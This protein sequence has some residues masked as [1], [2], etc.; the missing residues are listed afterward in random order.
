MGVRF[1]CVKEIFQFDTRVLLKHAGGKIDAFT[2]CYSLREA[3]GTNEKNSAKFVDLFC[4]FLLTW[5]L[6]LDQYLIHCDSSECFFSDRSAGSLTTQSMVV[7]FKTTQRRYFSE[8]VK[9]HNF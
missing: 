2:Y 6:D 5:A 9:V 3:R 7:K 4:G 1:L 8:W